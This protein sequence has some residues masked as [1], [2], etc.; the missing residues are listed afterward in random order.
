MSGATNRF[1]LTAGEVAYVL[2]HSGASGIGLVCSP[3]VMSDKIDI[4]RAPR[5]GDQGIWSSVQAV[6]TAWRSSR[7]TRSE[8]RLK[9]RIERRR[10]RVAPSGRYASRHCGR[11]GYSLVFN[12]AYTHFPPQVR[13]RAGGID[14]FRMNPGSGSLA[15]FSAQQGVDNPT[16]IAVSANH[17]FL[18]AINAVNEVDGVPGGAIEALAVD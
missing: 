5:K 17:R 4:S 9:R 2:Q 11:T 1:M 8:P 13:G 16:F 6:A 15:H 14:V 12:G 10:P 7:V 18:Y 3:A